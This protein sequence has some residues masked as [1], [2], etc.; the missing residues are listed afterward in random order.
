MDM[1]RLVHFVSLD[2]VVFGLCLNHHKYCAPTQ[3]HS[4]SEYLC[5]LDWHECMAVDVHSAV[6]LMLIQQM[7]SNCSLIN[8]KEKK[9][10]QNDRTRNVHLVRCEKWV[11]LLFVFFLNLT[12][13]AV[14]HHQYVVPV[15]TQR[16]RYAKA[17]QSI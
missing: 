13:L 11:A 4:C 2:Y 6:L 14:L 12:L 3:K 17:Q 10:N 16:Q 1:V 15:S 9:R 5:I 8:R 7:H